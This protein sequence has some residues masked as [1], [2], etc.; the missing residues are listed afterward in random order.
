MMFQPSITSELN[1]RFDRV[2][3]SRFS[4]QAF[5]NRDY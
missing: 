1:R 2:K 5:Y 4:L 3:Q